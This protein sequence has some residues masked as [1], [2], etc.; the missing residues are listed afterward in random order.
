MFFRFMILLIP[1]LMLACGGRIPPPADFSTDASRYHQI[2]EKRHQLVHALSGELS[3]EI[4]EGDE[5]VRARQLFATQ[6]PNRL[7]IDTLSPFEQPISTLI[8]NATQLAL[9]EI[10]QKRFQ[11]GKPNAE[12]LGRLSRLH[13]D[14]GALAT[15]LSGQPPLIQSTGGV[16]TWDEQRGLY[17]LTLVNPQSSIADREE[18]WIHPKAFT[19]VEIH[20]YQKNELE[21][22]LQLTDYTSHEPL[23]PQRLRFELPKHA[24]RVEVQLKDFALNPDL[25]SEAFQISTPPGLSPE[26][27]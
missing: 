1:C 19:T 23:L 26:P 9:H 16:V 13:L 6:P 3:L 21:V 24:I 27:M 4:W 22:R 12:H 20:L 18:L 15:I 25:P 10:N 17:K 5:R 8:M 14:P 2:F 11:I 7:R